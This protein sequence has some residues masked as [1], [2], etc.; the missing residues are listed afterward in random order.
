MSASVSVVM[1]VC[2][3][4]RFLPAQLASVLGQLQGDDELVVVDDASRDG[5]AAIL[6]AAED[7]R[8]RVVRNAANA[9][10]LRAFEKG[11]RLARHEIVFLC[12]QDDIWLPGKRSAFADAFARAPDVTVVISDAEV[13]DSAGRLQAPSFM[14]TRY[15]FAGTLGATLWRN[16]YLGCSMAVRRCV[17]TA[18]LPFPPGVPMHD[19]WLGVI[20][21][22][23][24]RVVYL[25]E[26]YLQYRRHD[27]NATPSRRQPW[28]R[29]LRWRAT[30]LRA[31]L[32]RAAFTGR[33]AREFR[34]WR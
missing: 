5:S 29:M 32:A 33:A 9:G 13:I 24:G 12:D 14:A 4:E 22:R 19:M 10:V 15:G 1:A 25:S 28:H 23:L 3:G 26:P 6:L 2:N 30:L 18:A 34:G 8:M 20:G 27:A 17:L 11:L 21:H 7:G 31:Y 16:R